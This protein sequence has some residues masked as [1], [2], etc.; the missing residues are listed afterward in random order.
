[1]PSWNE[2]SNSAPNHVNVLLDFVN[3]ATYCLTMGQAGG[4]FT[5][6]PEG[7]MMWDNSAKALKRL[8]SAVEVIQQISITGG[9]TGA[10]TASGARTN[11][12]V[13]SVSEAND[14]YM[15]VLSNGGDIDDP[16]QFRTNI[17]VYA[18]GDTYSASELDT[19]T[20]ERLRSD[21]N[22]SDV[23]STKLARE[24]LGI[25]TI[26]QTSG[27]SGNSIGI[28]VGWSTVRNAAGHYTVNYIG[29]NEPSA[30][31]SVISTTGVERRTFSIFY[32]SGKFD[33]WF[34]NESGTLTD[35]DFKS[36][37]IDRL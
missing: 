11:L 34:R 1:M 5:D 25:Y 15:Q 35:T 19:G 31:V 9:G 17:D 2:P 13:S 36:T 20:Q 33:I 3:K 7:E 22:L 21:S 29:L 10:S 16:D 8:T 26:S 18:K 14:L 32:Q 37:L 12:E 4:V 30:M 28:P 24:T 6:R 23:A 27:G